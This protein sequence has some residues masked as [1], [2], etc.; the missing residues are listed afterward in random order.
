MQREHDVLGVVPR[1]PRRN[2]APKPRHARHADAP[3]RDGRPHLPDEPP[4]PPPPT[5]DAPPRRPAVQNDADAP[6]SGAEGH[7]R[8]GAPRGAIARAERSRPPPPR[9]RLDAAA[10]E[11]EELQEQGEQRQH[12][13]HG[14]RDLRAERRHDRTPRGAVLVRRLGPLDVARERALHPLR[15]PADEPRH[16]VRAEVVATLVPRVVAEADPQ[17]VWQADERRA[18]EHGVGQRL[19]ARLRPGDADRVADERR[20]EP[21]RTARCGRVERREDGQRGRER[22]PARGDGRGLFAEQVQHG[23]GG[24]ERVRQGRRSGH[25]RLGPRRR[26]PERVRPERV[27]PG[28]AAARVKASRERLGESVRRLVVRPAGVAR[29]PDGQ[30]D[31]EDQRRQEVELERAQRPPP[32]ALD[33]LDRERARAEQEV[34]RRA[35]R[36]PVEAEVL[37]ERLGEERPER[38]PERL[39]LLPARRA[40]RP[41]ERLAAVEAGRRAGRG[42]AGR[43]HGC[44][45]RSRANV[46]ARSS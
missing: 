21:A 40:V 23:R 30:R 18:H 32:A 17:R 36:P 8:P 37:D 1:P 22:L 14:R 29:A 27:R 2:G 11:V 44:V 46:V 3:R 19:D 10:A 16:D 35:P 24:E 20:R 43:R 42:R 38:L 15:Q 12:S 13:E 5:P 25:R 31:E 4:P 6:R 7:P 26:C 45:A 34:T 28:G 9:P 33:V 39:R 41:D